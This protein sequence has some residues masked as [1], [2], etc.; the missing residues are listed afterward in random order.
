VIGND[1][2]GLFVSLQAELV[3]MPIAESSA[4]SEKPLSLSAPAFEIPEQSRLF[5]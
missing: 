1:F 5:E 3:R 2:A 4:A